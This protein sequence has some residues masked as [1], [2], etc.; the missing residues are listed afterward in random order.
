MCCCNSKDNRYGN[1]KKSYILPT[2]RTHSRNTSRNTSNFAHVII[3]TRNSYRM[4][5][6][7]VTVS[8]QVA[9]PVRCTWWG[10]KASRRRDEKV[11]RS[12]GVRDQYW[13][14]LWADKPGRPGRNRGR[15]PPVGRQELLRRVHKLSMCKSPTVDTRT[16]SNL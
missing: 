9:N 12:A 6:V 4:C 14:S 15:S 11:G 13:T 2:Q 5:S 10:N 1:T 8:N 16:S 3:V 7:I